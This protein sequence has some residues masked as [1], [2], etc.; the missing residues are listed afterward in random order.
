MLSAIYQFEIFWP[1]V[2]L[3]AVDVMNQLGRIEVATE[4]TL[5]HVTMFVDVGAT[6]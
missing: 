2:M 5:H 6:T 3:V 4:M 1:I